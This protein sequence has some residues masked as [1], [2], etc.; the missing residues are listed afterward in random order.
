[1]IFR[2]GKN[3]TV[4][5]IKRSDAKRF[6][7][8][9]A[10]KEIYDNTLAI[11]HPYTLK[12]AEWFIDFA[13][14]QTQARNGESVNFCIRDESGLLVGGCGFHDFEP[15]KSH[16]AEIGYW[17]GKRY[18]GRGWMTSVVNGLVNY[19]IDHFNLVHITAHV[20]AH[21]APSTRVLEKASFSMEGILK[22][23]YQK[24]GKIFDGK[25]FARVAK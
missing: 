25:L 1:M 11:P 2:V 4:D 8:L 5:L 10:D 16:K 19:G 21:N 23:H 18:W 20:F 17:L 12:D 13:E 14:K 9:L 22:S 15:G 3:L 24:D 7:E 6:V